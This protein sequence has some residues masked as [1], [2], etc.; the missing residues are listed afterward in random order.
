MA[1]G[2]GVSVSGTSISGLAGS[3][4]RIASVAVEGPVAPGATPTP[5]KQ[6][7]VGASKIPAKQLLCPLLATVIANDSGLAPTKLKLC[8]TRVEP[9]EFWMMMP[10]GAESERKFNGGM[11]SSTG[12]N[13]MPTPVRVAV[14]V[15]ALETTCSV[16]VRTPASVGVKVTLRTAA[17]FLLAGI[18]LLSAAATLIG[19][20][21]KSL[22]LVPTIEIELMTSA[23]FLLVLVTNS[24]ALRLEPTGMPP[25]VWFCRVPKSMSG[26]LPVVL[27][28]LLS[29]CDA[30]SAG[31]GVVTEPPPPPPPPP[32]PGTGE[33]VTGAGVVGAGVVGAVVVG[34]PFEA[35]EI[36]IRGL[37]SFALPQA[38]AES[39]TRSDAHLLF[40]LMNRVPFPGIAGG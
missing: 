10:S 2:S 15:P 34:P 37:I 24:C 17:A 28:E 11:A 16:P 18:A 30:A 25:V 22:G 21:E 12:G 23:V 38:T 13:A 35:L 3:L 9:P 40:K 29:V 33:E 14:A 5:R 19:S 31:A 1:L 6:N 26:E 20:T 4:D 39:S 8:S 36:P 32:P 27:P 7:D